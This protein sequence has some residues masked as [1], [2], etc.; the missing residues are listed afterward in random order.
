MEPIEPKT[1][2]RRQYS[3]LDIHRAAFDGPPARRSIGEVDAGILSRMRRTH[4]R[5]RQPPGLRPRQTL[6]KAGLP[7][8]MEIPDDA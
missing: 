4:A 7:P 8:T 5:R 1:A 6:D 2:S 3:S